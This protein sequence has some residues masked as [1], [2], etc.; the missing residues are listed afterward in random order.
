MSTL[1]TSLETG[2]RWARLAQIDAEAARLYSERAAV[3]QS[4]AYPVLK[5]PVEI[6]SLIFAH[7][8]PQNALNCTLWRAAVVLSSV[9][10]HWH[11]VALATAELWTSIPLEI[12]RHRP[13]KTAKGVKLWMARS[14][15]QPLALRLSPVSDP[16]DMFSDQADAWWDKVYDFEEYLLPV[17][18]L[19]RARWQHLEVSVPLSVLRRACNA[20]IKPLPELTHLSLAPMQ[21]AERWDSADSQE[22]VSLFKMAPKL[23]SLHLTVENTTD[24]Q[25][26]ERIAMPYLQLTTFIGTGFTPSECL[27]MLRLMPNL[28]H[29]AFSVSARDSDYDDERLPME[30]LKTLQLCSAAPT[31]RPQSILEELTLPRLEALSVGRDDGRVLSWVLVHLI[32][33][34]ACTIRFFS[35]EELNPEDVPECLDAL[36]NIETLELLN[37]AQD[38]AVRALRHLYAGVTGYAAPQ[39]RWKTLES[40]TLVCR[41]QLHHGDFP[42]TFLLELL[43]VL[44]VKRFHLLWDTSLLPRP[45]TPTEVAAF[46]GLGRPV[47]IGTPVFSWV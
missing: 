27:A 35:C 42:F 29:C 25:W 23:Q 9:C 1:D 2:A 40:L 31:A 34:S 17:V 26:I 24:F 14:K 36:P 3:A 47:Y 37:Y 20:D 46:R 28:V 13:K 32:E 5:L 39:P 41:K 6:T 22:S 10:R 21:E 19:H 8:V 7:C 4:L 43:E 38:A 15:T 45:P 30:H 11:A 18:L 33:R 16:G 44:P 12:D